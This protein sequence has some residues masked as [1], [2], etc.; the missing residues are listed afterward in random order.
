MTQDF[1]SC[2]QPESSESKIWPS[3]KQLPRFRRLWN[4]LLAHRFMLTPAR[5]PAAT[6]TSSPCRKSPILSH[7]SAECGTP[8]TVLSYS[9]YFSIDVNTVESGAMAAD[10][11]ID[12]SGNENSR[13]RPPRRAPVHSR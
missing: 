12:E 7:I 5:T 8:K 11:K 4:Q 3:R 1:R 13:L 6:S 9:S 2:L 10:I